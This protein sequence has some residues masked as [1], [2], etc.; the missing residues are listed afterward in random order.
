MSIS[1][2][3][4]ASIALSRVVQG[5]VAV[6][7]GPVW[8]MVKGVHLLWSSMTCVEASKNGEEPIFKS[9]R[10]V[11]VKSTATGRAPKMKHHRRE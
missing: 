2:R 7:L 6:Q 10:F 3:V 4:M 1:H 11:W 8:G 5:L 9:L